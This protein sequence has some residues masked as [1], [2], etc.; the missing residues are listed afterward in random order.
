MLPEY[1]IVFNV[2]NVHDIIG[3]VLPQILQN[4]ELY[5]SLIIILFLIFN[6][7]NCDFFLGFVVDYA[8][9]GTEGAFAE[10]VNYFISVAY[11]VSG[12][13]FVVAFVVI[14]T[15]IMVKFRLFFIFAISFRIL[16]F[17]RIAVFGVND[18]ARDFSL[19]AFTQKVNCF[20]V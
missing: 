10:E 16:S 2:N 14:E 4:F 3:I 12:Y 15:M 20:I 18:F 9:G 8:E 17:F 13:Y 11:V 19:F 1:D 7:F 5:R 6:Y